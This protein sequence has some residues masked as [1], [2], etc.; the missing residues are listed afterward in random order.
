MHQLNLQFTRANEPPAFTIPQERIL[1]PVGPVSV[2]LREG[3]TD[4]G[5]PSVTMV[6][7]LAGG[8][9]AVVETTW[10]LW[11]TSARAFAGRMEAWREHP[12]P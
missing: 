11:S 9:F 5:N 10:R 1:D 12:L 4:S 3:A 2:A 7:P 6:I 8:M